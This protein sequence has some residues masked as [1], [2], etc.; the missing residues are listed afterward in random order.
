MTYPPSRPDLNPDLSH[1]MQ[2]D[3]MDIRRGCPDHRWLRA[4]TTIIAHEGIFHLAESAIHLDGAT[5]RTQQLLREGDTHLITQTGWVGFASKGGGRALCVARPSA[6]RR[7][8]HAVS[9]YL[10]QWVTGSAKGS[11]KPL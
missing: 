9:R 8:A 11:V 1:D 7:M 5:I 4:G 6:W 3:L 10:R 2:C